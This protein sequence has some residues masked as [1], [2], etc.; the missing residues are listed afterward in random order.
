M[1]LYVG[2]GRRAAALRQYQACVATM[3]R[4]LGAEPETETKQLYQEILQRRPTE[5]AHRLSTR[6]SLFCNVQTPVP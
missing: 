6:V 2:Q 1:R 5:T 3:Q 4:E